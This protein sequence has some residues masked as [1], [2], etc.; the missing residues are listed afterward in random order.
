MSRTNTA[1]PTENDLE[2]SLISD[3]TSYEEGMNGPHSED[4]TRATLEEWNAILENDTFEAFSDYRLKPI[5]NRGEMEIEK[6]TA[7]QVPFGSKAIGSRWVYRMKQNPDGTT[8]Y[9]VRLV[10]KVWQQVQG[11]DYNE[12]FA[13]V[14][15]LTTLHLLLA[16]CASNHWKVRHLDV[17]MAFLNPKID[18]E[19]IYM[20]LPAGMDWVDKRTPKG[21]KV[22]LLKSLYGLK[23][24]P[25]IWYQAINTFLLSL[26]L[27]QS[28]ADPNLYVKD[29]VL[30]LLLYVDDI[31]IVS[32]SDNS[33]LSPAD[34]VITALKNKYKMS[35]LGEA[36]RFLGLEI[37]RNEDGIS[38]SQGSYIDTL[39]KRF[40]TCISPSLAP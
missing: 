32:M 16:L 20:E 27:K 1:D 7:I 8:R 40:E 2:A 15:K 35:D 21:A 12:T 36:R 38:L 17:V 18:N 39:L 22:R 30:L 14:S 29:R 19:N 4:W 25:R 26:D 10:G 5:P 9:K 24:S 28:S 31:L 11:I 37:N 3:P 13:P 23:Q 34:E 33:S 6:H